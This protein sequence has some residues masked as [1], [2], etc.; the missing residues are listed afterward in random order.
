MI[1]IFLTLLLYVIIGSI[2]LFIMF[3]V[4]KIIILIIA[5]LASLFMQLPDWLKAVIVILLVIC[6]VSVTV[7]IFKKI[8]KYAYEFYQK[9]MMKI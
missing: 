4:I 7:C 8:Q 1:E 6:G 5:L 2:G 9:L 3:E